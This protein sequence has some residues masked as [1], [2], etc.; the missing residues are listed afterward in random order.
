ML[1]GEYWR[2]MAS[3]DACSADCKARGRRFCYPLDS[4][5]RAIS[6]VV[7]KVVPNL[8]G[9]FDMAQKSAG[10]LMYRGTGRELA[11]LLVHPGGP[12]W[13]KKDDGAWSIPKGLYT[14][15]EDPLSAAKREFQEETGAFVDGQ[16]TDL[17]EFKQP[18]GKFIAAWAV[19]GEFDPTRLQSNTFAME[20]PPKSGRQQE[21][22]EVD[23]AGWFRPAEAM[24]KILKGQKPILEKFLVQSGC[25]PDDSVVSDNNGLSRDTQSASGQGSSF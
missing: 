9:E 15:E 2:C 6:A 22:P 24:R 17:G 8:P 4:A 16:F 11:V 18:S 14:P 19:E 7:G 5:R 10:I 13:A 12:F 1:R 23:K 21:F 3:R 25:N 20:W